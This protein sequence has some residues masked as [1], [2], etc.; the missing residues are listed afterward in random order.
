MRKIRRFLVLMGIVT[1]T[2]FL[3]SCH[4]EGDT[5]YSEINKQMQADVEADSKMAQV[6]EGKVPEGVSAAL[7][8]TLATQQP[9]QQT[10]SNEKRFDVTVNNMPAQTFFTGLVK[11][12]PYNIV[13]SQGVQGNVTLNQ[14]NVTI[15]EALDAVRDM[16]GYQYEVTPYG[17]K[18]IPSGL[19]TRIFR[20]N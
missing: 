6:E 14:K 13:V 10:Q 11:D 9:V 18:V 15:R 2:L 1:A 12:T 19:E 7:M 8:P 17:Y 5:A 4:I 20:V 3:V 16:Y